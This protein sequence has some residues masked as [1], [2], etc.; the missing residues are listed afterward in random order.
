MLTV[1]RPPS[2]TFIRLQERL[3]G[4]VGRA[5]SDFRMIEKDDTVMVCL[6]GGK[7][8]HALLSVLLALQRR[9]PVPFRLIVVNLD[10]KQPGFPADVLPAYL[11]SL[12]VAYHIIEA[13]TYSI[14]REKIP[15]GK[16]TCSLCSRLR[17]GVIYRTAKAIGANKIAL[18]HHRDD[19]IETLFLNMFYG[20]RLKAMP[21][22]LVTDDG[23]HT[24]IRP[25]AYCTEKDLAT[26][27]RHMRFPIIPCDLCG[28]QENLKR[29]AIKDWLKQ[30]DKEFPGRV[31]NI[32]LALQSVT[33]SHLADTTLFDFANLEPGRHA[34]P[35]GDTLFD[36]ETLERG[37]LRLSSVK[38]PRIHFVKAENSDKIKD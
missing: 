29:R 8:S 36:Q 22:K 6:S 10:Q 2:A 13:D 4:A 30:Q 37:A 33:P 32:F 21:P 38:G 26:Y 19:I 3:R 28:S 5:I 20:G 12:G 23:Y 24:V 27:A 17:R 16:T 25:L 14:V 31:D 9:A 11:E 7:D 1:E 34:D 35:E 15:E 18:G